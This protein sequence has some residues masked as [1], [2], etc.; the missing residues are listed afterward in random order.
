MLD[1][2]DFRFGQGVLGG[3][4]RVGA[5]E[6]KYKVQKEGGGGAGGG[7]GSGGKGGGGDRKKIIRKTQKLNRYASFTFFSFS[8][9]CGVFFLFRGWPV[10]EEGRGGKGREGRMMAGK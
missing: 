1:D 7:G 3:K 2:T 4:M 9:G 8:P 5:A 6:W 10:G